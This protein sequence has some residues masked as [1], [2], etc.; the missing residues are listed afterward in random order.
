MYKAGGGDDRRLF[1]NHS[2]EWLLPPLPGGGTGKVMVFDNGRD[3]EDMRYSTVHEIELP[4]YEDYDGSGF[5][6]ME[7]DGSFTPATE[8]WSY[9]D[10]DNFYSNFISGQQRL[11][12]GHTLIA[13]GMR[14]RIFEVTSQSEKVWE[15]VSPVVRTGP[16][17]QGD[18]IPPFSPGN[19]RQQNTVFRAR[20]YS[21]DYPGL[22]GKDLSPKGNIEQEPTSTEE[23]PGIPTSLVL[24]QNY[25]NPFTSSTTFSF[26]LPEAGHAQLRVYD[27]IGQHVM[28]LTDRVY[29]AGTHTLHLDAAQLPGGVYFYRLEAED[30]HT[31][32]TM[33]LIR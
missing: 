10:P 16:L 25:P 32:R 22:E 3:R 14:G 17:T 8:V 1:F 18:P 2:T 30:F 15:Y 33:L 5:Y 19:E 9:S 11:P 23:A 12:N 31:T 4:Y 26:T 7:V 24:H 27:T 20:R 29:S 21:V 6:G 13:E 28:T